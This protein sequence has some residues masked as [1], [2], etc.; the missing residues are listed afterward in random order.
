MAQKQDD[1]KYEYSIKVGQLWKMKN[2]TS[3]VVFR[4]VEFIRYYGPSGPIL[5]PN[6]SRTVNYVVM[7]FVPEDEVE[8]ML[9]ANGRNMTCLVSVEDMT[10]V[11]CFI[12]PSKNGHMDVKCEKK[13]QLFR[14]I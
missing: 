12:I 5:D 4:V 10:K 1:A 3:K 8:K 14:D 6:H 7:Q 9:S 13:W 2:D 11:D